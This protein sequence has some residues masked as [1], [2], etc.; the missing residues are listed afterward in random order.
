[1]C[2]QEYRSFPPTDRILA[3]TITCTAQAQLGQ[4][5]EI[6]VGRVGGKQF[7]QGGEGGAGRGASAGGV[8]GQ[9][10]QLGQVVLGH[11]GEALQSG[12]CIHLQTFRVRFS[13]Y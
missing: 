10:R 5:G 6:F 8:L 2:S 3:R 12:G 13:L 7:G 9:A 4:R 11:A 1:M